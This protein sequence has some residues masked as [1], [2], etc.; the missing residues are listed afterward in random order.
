M[1]TTGAPKKQT[2]SLNPV[3][4]G[5]L[6]KIK[7]LRAKR[8]GQSGI[9]KFLF[10]Q[11]E[12][13]EIQ[14]VRHAIKKDIHALKGQIDK[15]TMQALL[16]IAETAHPKDKGSIYRQIAHELKKTPECNSEV[17]LLL[18][19]S[20][21][22]GF[23]LDYNAKSLLD[24]YVTKG[25]DSV[26]IDQVQ[27]LIQ[28]TT[29]PRDSHTSLAVSSALVNL[30]S[31]CS[32]DSTEHAQVCG[33]LKMKLCTE[34]STPYK[35]IL[36]GLFDSRNDMNAGNFYEGTKKWEV[37][38]TNL[39]QYGIELQASE[40]NAEH[41]NELSNLAKKLTEALFSAHPGNSNPITNKKDATSTLA[42]SFC[43]ALSEIKSWI[44]KEENR[45]SF[46]DC[47]MH[48]NVGVIRSINSWGYVFDRM[49]DKDINQLT[50]NMLWQDFYWGHAVEPYPG[51]YE[52]TNAPGTIAGL[53]EEFIVR[54]DEEPIENQPLFQLY[55]RLVEES[56]EK[57]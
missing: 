12:K 39:I 50:F 2:P 36:Q 56:R 30:L 3:T 57:Y 45:A 18:N 17:F 21:Y 49:S 8:E 53:H 1:P 10:G 47:L 54:L 51:Q 38:M 7:E 40:A 27:T 13:S 11:K 44:L 19:K 37:C 32:R 26:P 55:K 14:A 43:S 46:E 42:Y 23:P 29:I 35:Q 52:E 5:N 22:V 48:V 31:L 34:S 20:K 24:A 16:D 41:F 9:R 6:E 4:A 15:D 33:A 28:N 25:Q